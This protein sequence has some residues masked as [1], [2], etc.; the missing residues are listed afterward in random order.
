MVKGTP[1]TMGIAHP[2]RHPRAVTTPTVET[3]AE[4]TATTIATITLLPILPLPLPVRHPRHQA[5]HHKC[6]SVVADV[7][8]LKQRQRR[9][10][11]LTRH[12]VVLSIKWGFRIVLE[13]L[14]FS[15]CLLIT[16]T[17]HSL[18][19]PSSSL[20]SSC[21]PSASCCLLFTPL[22]RYPSH[23]HRLF[24]NWSG[25]LRRITAKKGIL[26]GF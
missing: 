17:P 12:F 11:V 16:L 3:I 5:L 15:T 24:L 9:C 10:V 23:Y 26:D 21:G 22:S 20:P 7:L 6:A 18:F 4:T 8:V 25:T 13:L 19:T 14:G 2:L 1:T